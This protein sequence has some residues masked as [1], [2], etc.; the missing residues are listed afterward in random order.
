MNNEKE[1]YSQREILRDMA[2]NISEMKT[3]LAVLAKQQE[4]NDKN[5]DRFDRHINNENK[6]KWTERVINAVVALITGAGTH[7]TMK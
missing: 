4:Y 2:T 3:S 6:G 5:F 1:Q 7:Y